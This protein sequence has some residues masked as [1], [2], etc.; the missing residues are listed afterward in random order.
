DRHPARQGRPARGDDPRGERSPGP[1]HP[2][3]RR[4][5][6]RA[7]RGTRRRPRAC[8]GRPCCPPAR[9]AGG[10]SIDQAMTSARSLAQLDGFRALRHRNF[11]LFWSGQLISLVG[12]WMQSVAQGWLVLTLTN[13]P[14]M[15]GVV[16]AAQFIPVMIFGLFGGIVADSLP[17][18]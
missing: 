18:R 13:D 12:T 7:G 1:P 8:R 6:R 10:S 11:R 4:D 15:L 14:F 2:A 3:S 16:A 5:R 9:S 17:K